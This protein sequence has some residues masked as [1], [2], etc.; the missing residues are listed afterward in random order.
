MQMLFWWKNVEDGHCPS[1]GLF[2]DVLGV[3]G[4]LINF[5]CKTNRK[6]LAFDPRTGMVQGKLTTLR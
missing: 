5:L 4:T 6:N 1:M 3:S 2:A